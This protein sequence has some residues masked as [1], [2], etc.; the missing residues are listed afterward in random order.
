MIHLQSSGSGRIPLRRLNPRNLHL[1]KK[2]RDLDRQTPTYTSDSRLRSEV[3]VQTVL[4]CLQ[5]GVSQRSVGCEF[6]E[7]ESQRCL[8]GLGEVDGR[9]ARAAGRDIGDVG[10]GGLGGGAGDG[11][12]DR[13]DYISDFAGESGAADYEAGAGLAGGEVG[14]REGGGER[15]EREGEDRSRRVHFDYLECQMVKKDMRRRYSIMGM[16]DYS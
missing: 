4:K 5:V 1:K 16:N 10:N 2:L 15:Q 3:N 6:G 14:G 7:C 12:L 11:V 13:G 9:E 8:R